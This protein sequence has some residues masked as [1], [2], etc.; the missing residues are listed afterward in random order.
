MSDRTTVPAVGSVNA[1]AS[2]ARRRALFALLAAATAAGVLWLALAAV[3]P[4]SAAAVLFIALFAV[5]LPWSVVGFWNAAIGFLIMTGSRDPVAAVNPMA[6]RIRGDETVTSATA[7]LVCVRNEAPGQ[8]TRNLTPLLDGLV[9][10]DVAHL[11][12][13]YLLSDTGDPEV[14]AAEQACFAAFAARWR[15]AVAIVYRRRALNTGFKAGNIRDFCDRWGADHELAVTLDADSFMP[16]ETILRLV[17][18]MQANPTLGILQTLVVGLP[19]VSAFARLFQ[20]GMRLGMRSHTLGSAWWQGDCGPYWGHNAILRLEPFVAHCRLPALTGGGPLGGHILSHDQVEA[21]LMRRAGYE[22]RVLPVEGVS[23][24]ENPPT[25]V[26][27]IRRDLRWCQGNMQ[28]WR[29]LGLPG[30]KPVSRFQL[31]FAILMYLGSPAWMALV[32][33]GALAIAFADAA[34]AAAQ[35]RPGAGSALF[36]I[37]LSMIFAP[38]L[39]SSLDVLMRRSARRSY[40]G[41]AQFILNVAGETLFSLLLSPVMAL[42]HTVFLF[43]LFVLR[44]GGVWNRQMRESHAVPW[45][46]AWASLWPHTLAGIAVIGLAATAAAGDIGY[47]LL[48]AGGL[49]LSVPFAVAT[50]AP[51]LGALLARFGVGRIPEETEPPKVLLSLRLPAI[52]AGAP[53]AWRRFRSPKP[54]TGEAG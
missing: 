54:R 21:A 36:A 44:R 18:I 47:A 9:A 45:R 20:F 41:A 12:R 10:A 42:T 25:L 19:T 23:W 14:V 11:F 46:L 7:I 40:G 16:A 43:R 52:E 50:A 51:V 13:V 24:E 4:R 26:E 15:D 29:L 34:G 17:R 5:T 32:A 31:L 27:Y 28:Y 49:A 33:I 48:A 8:V 1:T 37:V 22:V 35:T 2:L 38:K 3:P 39:A 30:L 53:G 6:A